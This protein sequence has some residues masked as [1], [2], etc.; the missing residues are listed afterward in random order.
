MLRPTKKYRKLIC[1]ASSV[2]VALLFTFIATSK[3]FA[4]SI[5]AYIAFFIVDAIIFAGYIFSTSSGWSGKQQARTTLLFASGLAIGCVLHAVTLVPNLD[6]ISIESSRLHKINWIWLI[7]FA[8]GPALL[9]E[10]LLRGYLSDFF[11]H[12]GI[13]LV[14]VLLLQGALFSAI[15][16]AP[17]NIPRT[18]FFFMLAALFTLG[19]VYFDGL[20]WPIGVH[21][22]WNFFT[23]VIYGVPVSAA[24]SAGFVPLSAFSPRNYYLLIFCCLAVSIYFLYKLNKQRRVVSK[25]GLTTANLSKQ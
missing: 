1:L 11:S 7:A 14:I 9:E 13:S 2:I 6:L 20:A 23:A 5:G 17:D 15:H 25:N 10:A 19:R 22:S 8:L 12:A 4:L 21:F 18:A 24:Q 16:F 3:V